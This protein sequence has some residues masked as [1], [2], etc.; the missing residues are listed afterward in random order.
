MKKLRVLL[1]LLLALSFIGCGPSNFEILKKEADAGDPVKQFDLAMKYYRGNSDIEKKEFYLKKSADSGYTKAKYRLAKLYIQKKENEKAFK[2]LKDA[3]TGGYDKA[4]VDL[5]V[6]FLNGKIVRKDMEKGKYWLIKAYEQGHPKA[7][8]NLGIMSERDKNYTDA[9]K[10]YLTVINA[11][12]KK[13]GERDKLNVYFYLGEVERLLNNKVEACA[14]FSVG[15][16]MN[17]YPGELKLIDYYKTF[18]KLQSELSEDELKAAYQKAVKYQYDTFTKYVLGF[19][20]KVKVHKGIIFLDEQTYKSTLIRVYIRLMGEYN[21]IKNF[22]GKT[23]KKSL[24]SYSLYN[25]MYGGKMLKYASID[26]YYGKC[27][28][29]YKEADKSLV[30]FSGEVEDTLKEVVKVQISVLEGLTKTQKKISNE[31]NKI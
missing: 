24:M 11:D 27:L 1:C 5:A 17:T 16:V 29:K 21:G 31:Y 18:K 23:D 6:A 8:F 19:K 22:K 25:L 28:L 3:A 13:S 9:R 14:W 7:A 12:L 2:Y 10:Y 15:A 20:E 30:T 26:G 4:Q